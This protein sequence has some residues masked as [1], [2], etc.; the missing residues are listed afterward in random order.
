MFTPKLGVLRGLL[1]QVVVAQRRKVVVFSQWRAMLRLSEWAVRD[2]LEGAGLRSVFFT[3]AES[4]KLRERAIIDFHDDPS[5]AV[6]FLSDAGG[7]GLNLQR[8]AS[9]CINLELPWN[10]AVLEQRIGRIYR[11]GQTLPIDVYNLV[12]EEGAVEQKLSLWRERWGGLS[13]WFVSEGPGLSQADS[14]RNRARSAIPQLLSALTLLNERRSGKSDRSADF[15]TLARWFAECDGDDDAHRMYRAAFA[16]SPARHLSLVTDGDG[17]SAST[18][19]AEAK[20]LS[21]HPKLR[22]RGTLSPRG[23]PPPVRDRSRERA[24]LRQRVLEDEEHLERARQRL[25]RGEP[26]LL[27]ELGAL[28]AHELRLLL[29]LLGEALSA[30]PHPDATVERTSGDGLLH[31][32]LE[33]LDASHA[34]TSTRSWACSPDA[35]TGSPCPTRGPHERR[36]PRS[37]RRRTRARPP[38]PVDAPLADGRRRALHPREASPRGAAHALAARD[39]LAARDRA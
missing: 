35:I 36:G 31:L 34:P 7:V 10:P 18:P 29:S 38:R 23:A 28:D 27:S 1:D 17:V 14:L 9:A 4:S 25:A 22:E 5:V 12:S 30:Q 13:R 21:I 24:L 16:L 37:A 20:P 6:M 19:W 2:L 11:L 39:G 26:I 15:R 3:G 33:P 8:A 32:R